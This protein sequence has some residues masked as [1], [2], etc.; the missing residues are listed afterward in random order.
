[1]QIKAQWLTDT[2][3]LLQAGSQDWSQNHWPQLA[4]AC[5]DLADCQEQVVG[6]DSLLLVF[7]PAHRH[8]LVQ[9]LPQL[10]QRLQ[11]LTAQ[12]S[13]PR[14]LQIPVHYGGTQGPDLVRVAQHTGLSPEQ[15][16]ELHSQAEYQV[17]CLGFQP[18]FAYLGGLPAALSTPRLDQPR[19]RVPAGSVA[20]GANQT[21]IYPSHSPGG[22]N[23][24]GQTSVPLFDPYADPPCLLQAGDR[25]RFIASQAD[26]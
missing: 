10:E 24:I 18:G 4:A 3:L 8:L 17:L 25:V 5:Q 20:I 22:W 19:L 7:G 13:S 16:I 1:M 11:C 6:L 2:A 23:L 21:G 26:D 14:L 12:R 15:V 9:L